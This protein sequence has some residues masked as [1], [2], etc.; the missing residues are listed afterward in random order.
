MAMIHQVGTPPG[1]T[2]AGKTAA[3]AGAARRRCLRRICRFAP[4]KLI[5]DNDGE[6][7]SLPLFLCVVGEDGAEEEKG[8]REEGRE[9]EVDCPLSRT[10]HKW[11]ARFQDQTRAA[12]EEGG[13]E[14]GARKRGRV[15]CHTCQTFIWTGWEGHRRLGDK[16]NSR[17]PPPPLYLR[18]GESCTHVRSAVDGAGKENGELAPLSQARCDVTPLKLVPASCSMRRQFPLLPSTSP[19]E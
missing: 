1:R 13:R 17:R 4:L 6:L 11:S 5:P 12:E 3:P 14:E 9:V 15:F 8:G 16:S 19:D 2:H 10:A 7:L 18:T